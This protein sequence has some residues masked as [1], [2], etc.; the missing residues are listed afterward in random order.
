MKTVKI[1]KRALLD[2]K[3]IGK[4]LRIENK[5]TSKR[6]VTLFEYK[7]SLLS[8]NPKLGRLL[9]LNDPEFEGMRILS[10]K[11]GWPWLIFYLE[12]ETGLQIIR[13]LH[14]K[15]NYSQELKP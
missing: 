8:Q 3:E 5:E 14:G 10:L 11:S 7:I 13:V 15:R 4:E 9:N 6:F 1:R 2:V 12:T